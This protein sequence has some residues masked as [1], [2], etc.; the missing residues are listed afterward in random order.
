MIWCIQ[1]KN[2]KEV[3][4][5]SKISKLFNSVNILNLMAVFAFMITAFNVNSTC[6]YFAHQEKIPEKAKKLRKF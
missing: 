6:M 4:K 1:I 2:K 5:F 3:K